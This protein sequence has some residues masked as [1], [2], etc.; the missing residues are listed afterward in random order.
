MLF[1]VLLQCLQKTQNPKGDAPTA[2]QLI[3][4]QPLIS[5]T[6]WALTLPYRPTSH[7]IPDNSLVYKPE[8]RLCTAFL[9]PLILLLAWRSYNLNTLLSGLSL[10]EVVK[11]YWK[12]S[13]E[14]DTNA[15]TKRAYVTVP[16]FSLAQPT[17]ISFQ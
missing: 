1:K 11:G 8:F 6:C 10:L 15:E 16:F 5:A 4:S 17:R 3:S 2:A 14:T 13:Y 9:S 12:V 7:L